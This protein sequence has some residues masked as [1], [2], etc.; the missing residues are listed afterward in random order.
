MTKVCMTIKNDPILVFSEEKSRFEIVNKNRRRIEVHQVDNCLITQG[1]RCDWLL[2]DSESGS[3]C[4]IE[5]K[6]SDI[7]HAVAQ[8]VAAVQQLSKRAGRRNGYI[9]CARNPLSTTE[10]QLLAKK[11]LKQYRISLR[12][13]RSTY[14]ESIDGVM[15]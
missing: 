6:G 13:K 10:V 9:I 14:K 7:K 4:F 2:I 1:V 15:A 12:V 3:E 8:L 11:L 5:L